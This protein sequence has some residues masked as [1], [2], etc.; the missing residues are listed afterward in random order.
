MNRSDEMRIWAFCQEQRRQ[1]DASRWLEMP[2]ATREEAAAVSLFL[3]GVDWYGYRE[4]LR[5]VADQLVPG[6]VDHFAELALRVQFDC[7]RF[8]SMLRTRLS[9]D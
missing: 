5:K 7:P 6:C 3:A 4:E 8:S 9:H 1:F 2:G